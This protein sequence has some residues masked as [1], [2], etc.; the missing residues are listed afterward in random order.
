MLELFKSYTT[1]E[2]ILAALGIPLIQAFFGFMNAVSTI[3]VT[4]TISLGAWCA[5]CWFPLLLLVFTVVFF[6]PQL[7]RCWNVV[8]THTTTKVKQFF[9]MIRTHLKK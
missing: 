3:I 5:L 1:R 6:S 8:R 7:N 4:G 2:N 9:Q